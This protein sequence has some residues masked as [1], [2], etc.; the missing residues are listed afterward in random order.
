MRQ[1]YR[2]ASAC[3]GLWFS[4]QCGCLTGASFYPSA[5][6]AEGVLSLPPSVR[7]S[8]RLSVRRQLLVSAITRRVFKLGLPNLHQMCILGPSRTLL[9][10]VLIDLD[11]Q[12]H[13]GVKRPKLAQNGLVRTITLH[14][15]E[16]GSP[17]LHQICILG[18]SRTLWEMV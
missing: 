15:Y 11:L 2:P 4:Y 8:V 18:P 3:A 7:L 13:L 6:S 14:A 12:G 17:N 10:M 1:N 9:K 5:T 16:L